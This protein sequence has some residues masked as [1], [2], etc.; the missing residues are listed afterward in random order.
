[1]N[2]L[3]AILDT[4]RYRHNR[5]VASL[6]I[7]MHLF[8]VAFK[9]MKSASDVKMRSLCRYVIFRQHEYL[10]RSA[11]MLVGNKKQGN[12]I[13]DGR[14]IIVVIRIMYDKIVGLQGDFYSCNCGVPFIQPYPYAI[15]IGRYRPVDVKHETMWIEKVISF[16]R[17][18]YYYN[19]CVIRNDMQEKTRVLFRCN[20]PFWAWDNDTVVYSRTITSV[21]K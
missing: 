1:M 18:F 2:V 4:P 12:F 10:D 20:V 19:F 15:T 16:S 17:D 13:Y 7:R 8:F 14:G 11:Y 9:K 6:N 5:R 21:K 3:T